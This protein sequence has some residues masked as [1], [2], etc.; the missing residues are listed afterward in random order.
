MFARAPRFDAAMPSLA[1]CVV[2][3]TTYSDEVIAAKMATF[4]VQS[5]RVTDFEQITPFDFTFRYTY[6]DMSARIQA[7]MRDREYDRVV[8]FAA[9]ATA[10]PIMAKS[11]A[12]NLSD[13]YRFFAIGDSHSVMVEHMDDLL[14][15][16]G[17]DHPIHANALLHTASV[18]ERYADRNGF[19]YAHSKFAD[20][21]RR[22][23]V[24]ALLDDSSPPIRRLA[25]ETLCCMKDYLRFLQCGGKQMDKEVAAL[26]SAIGG[27]GHERAA[28][29]R[30][31]LFNFN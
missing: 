30:D 13:F 3:D 8:L 1:R 21:V 17:G 10:D 19:F 4:F 25:E 9:A 28:E 31:E 2:Y 12:G 15:M 23:A 22:F 26:E 11:V 20:N 27:V 14:N 18:F 16:L 6:R 24:A 7:S 5:S 29:L